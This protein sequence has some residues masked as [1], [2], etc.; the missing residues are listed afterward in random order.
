M[1]PVLEKKRGQDAELEE[2]LPCAFEI[3]PPVALWR[4][5]EIICLGQAGKCEGTSSSDRVV[6]QELG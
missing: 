5:G 3:D 6:G 2:Y 1:S 4:I